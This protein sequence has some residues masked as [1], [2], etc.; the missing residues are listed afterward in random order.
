MLVIDFINHYSYLINIS[1]FS[2]KW[3]FYLIEVLTEENILLQ[4]KGDDYKF[5]TN[6]YYYYLFEFQQGGYA[7]PSRKQIYVPPQ[8][9][10]HFDLKGAPPKVSYIKQVLDLVK[11]LGAT[12]VLLEWEDMFPYKGKFST[13]SRCSANIGIGILIFILCFIKHVS[14]V[15]K[16][17]I[18]TIRL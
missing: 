9:I 14:L 13:S 5:R 16:L 17:Q 1:L 15:Y 7:A 4:T 2:L 3:R 10:V 18:G 6:V 12:G 8:R 11:H